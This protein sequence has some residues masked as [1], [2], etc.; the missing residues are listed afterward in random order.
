MLSV[1]T[2][3]SSLV[4]MRMYA[5]QTEAVNRSLHRL[6]TGKRINRAADDPSGLIA[7]DNMAARSKAINTQI[8]GLERASYQSAASEGAYSVISD[9]LVDLDSLVV[10]AANTG[11]SSK[12]EREAL[13]IEADSIIEGIDHILSTS[14]FN[15]EKLFAG[16]TADSYGSV[17]GAL[18]EG[19]PSAQFDLSDLKTGGSLNLVD[20]HVGLA[21]ELT[22]ASSGSVVEIRAG[23][24]NLQKNYYD[25][26][27]SALQRELET[28]AE[29][30]SIIRD[31]DYAK[32]VTEL[33]RAQILQQVALK[34]ILIARDQNRD[35]VFALLA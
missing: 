2:N 11:A 3:I 31:T 20:G 14:T 29:T 6:S 4:G 5:Q 26:E 21:Q 30:E 1:R 12:E 23:I 33:V 15:G 22:K 32:E 24:G 19:G 17:T 27:I 25:R 28:L 10:Q 13:Q 34:T 8:K 18:T 35:A 7:A 16:R 9:M